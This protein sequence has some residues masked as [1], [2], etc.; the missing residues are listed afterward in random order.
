MRKPQKKFF[1]FVLK[2]ANIEP[3]QAVYIEDRI[4]Y[5]NIARSIGMNAILFK[6]VNQIKRE[7]KRLGIK[8]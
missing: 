6:D 8:I 3:C 5:V 4:E 1:R 7:L 2:K